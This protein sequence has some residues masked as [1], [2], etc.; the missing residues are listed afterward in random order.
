MGISYNF[1]KMISINL[2]YSWIGSD[3]T[4]GNMTNDANKDSFVAADERSLN[5]PKH[6]GFIMLGFQNLLKNKLFIKISARFVGEYDFYSGSQ[7]S[8]RMGEG[9]RGRVF[10]R[11]NS[12]TGDST[13]VNKNFNWGPLGGFTTFDL[14]MGYRINTMMS[15]GMGITNVFDIKQREFAGSAPIG[16]LIMFELKIHIPD[17]K[18][19]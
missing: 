8:T 9:R 1:N 17:K 19:L 15:V 6:R 16:R 4:Q 14:N 13:F 10:T 2:N 18:N 12:Q 11:I 5:C 7:I 3:I